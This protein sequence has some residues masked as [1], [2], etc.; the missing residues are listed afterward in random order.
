MLWYKADFYLS[1]NRPESMLTVTIS[2]YNL[3]GHKLWSRTSTGRSDMY[4]SSPVTWD[5]TDGTGRRVPRGIYVYS[6]TVT[7]DGENFTT[8]SRKIAVTS[9]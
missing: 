1:H 2:V 5:L 3:L 7:A 6:A 4:L 9:R 8:A